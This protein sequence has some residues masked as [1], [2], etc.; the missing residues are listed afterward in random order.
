MCVCRMGCQWRSLPAAFPKWTAVYY[1]FRRWQQDGTLQQLNHAL[2]QAD[3]QAQ[4]QAATP[5]ILCLDSQSV[6]LVPCIAEHRSTDGSKCV[7]GR[8]RQV[9][10]DRKGRVWCCAHAANL[11]DSRAA[12]PPRRCYANGATGGHA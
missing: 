9:L 10:V 5:A 11:H 4:G 3:R 6:K 7:N 1:H 2:N 12:A 8:K